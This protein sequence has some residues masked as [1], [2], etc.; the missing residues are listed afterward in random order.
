MANFYPTEVDRF[1]T[2]CTRTGK[3]NL[4]LDPRY[5][6]VENIETALKTVQDRANVTAQILSQPHA[7]KY[8]VPDVRAQDPLFFH[9]RP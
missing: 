6:Q 7:L 5:I 2:G 8:M 1:K 4:I 9:Y 3:Q